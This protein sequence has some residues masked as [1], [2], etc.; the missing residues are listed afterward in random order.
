MDGKYMEQKRKSFDIALKKGEIGEQIIRE[1]LESGG[2][3][4][5][6]PQTKNK[7]H[8]FDILATKNKEKVI[9]IDVKTKARLNKWAAQ[10]INI[11]SYNEYMNFVEKINI[12]FYLVFVDDKNGDVHMANLKEL[13]NGFNPAPHIIA[14]YLK[15]MKYLFN[16]GKEKITELSEFDQRNYYFNPEPK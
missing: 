9:A 1:Y 6:F 4:V 8:Y 7:A 2:Y 15:D 13:V 14:W 12:P 3:I 16:I 11:K 10:G 5:Y